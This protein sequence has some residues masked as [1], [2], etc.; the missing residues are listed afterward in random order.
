MNQIHKL[1]GNSENCLNVEMKIQ[2]DNSMQQNAVIYPVQHEYDQLN[3]E[4][5]VDEYEC[6]DVQEDSMMMEQ[7]EGFNA[8]AVVQEEEGM[9]EIDEDNE[10][11]DFDMLSP[12]C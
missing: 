11:D 3:T 2:D 8:V 5:K 12:D 7:Q 6:D 1:K 10:C 4:R 9:M